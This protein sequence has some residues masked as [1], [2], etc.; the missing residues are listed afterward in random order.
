MTTPIRLT[1][2]PEDSNHV[3][4][5]FPTEFAGLFETSDWRAVSHEQVVPCAAVEIYF[6]R[7]PV[8]FRVPVFRLLCNILSI[9]V[10]VNA[11]SWLRARPRLFMMQIVTAERANFSAIAR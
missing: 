9:A 5:W 6:W 7:P 10:G 8:F 2:A 1:E 4:E 3:Q 11:L